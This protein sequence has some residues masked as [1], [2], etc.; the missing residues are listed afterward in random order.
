MP[1]IQL[2]YGM[3]F[4]MALFSALMVVLSPHAVYSALYLVLT[5][6]SIAG[7]FVMMNAQLAAAFQIIVYAGA[8]VVLFLFVIM[9][10]QLGREAP[11][12]PA[13]RKVRIAGL[14]LTAVFV[15]QLIAALTQLRL[16]RGLSL[17]AAP[18]VQ[19][20]DVARLSLTQYIYA[21]EMTSVLLLAAVVGAVVLARK[22]MEA[23]GARTSPSTECG[24]GNAE[25]G[26]ED[27]IIPPAKN[28]QSEESAIRNPQLEGADGDVRAP[29][30]NSQSGGLD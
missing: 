2:I 1:L 12:P 4:V 28:P 15:V 17:D 23:L 24:M 7:L 29:G 3:L 11:P 18:A 14:I 27:S 6:I 26:I 10:L 25:S 20:R 30:N 13:L 5:M 9:L 19:I 21:F 22:Q 8:I 16:P